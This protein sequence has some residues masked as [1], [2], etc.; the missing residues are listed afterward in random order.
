MSSLNDKFQVVLLRNIESNSSNKPNQYKIAL[1][2][3]L[4]LFNECVMLMV[5]LP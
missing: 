2:K 1:A 3:P 4:D 5:L